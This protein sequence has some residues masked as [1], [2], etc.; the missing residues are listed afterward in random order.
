MSQKVWILMEIRQLTD[1][2]DEATLE[3]A[4]GAK[5]KFAFTSVLDEF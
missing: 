1:G 5:R 3:K 4:N 2:E